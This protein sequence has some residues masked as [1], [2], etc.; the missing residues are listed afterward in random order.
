MRHLSEDGVADGVGGR[1]ILVL[2]VG[3][4]GRGD[5]DGAGS[6]EAFSEDRLVTSGETAVLVGDNFGCSEVTE[7]GPI[8]GDEDRLETYKV[9][10]TDYV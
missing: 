7:D 9:S 3:G 5:D 10:I 6:G 8:L 4:D 1:M 2:G